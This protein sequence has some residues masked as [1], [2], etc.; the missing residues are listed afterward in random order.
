M[1][2]AARTI[3]LAL[4]DGASDDVRGGHLDHERRFSPASA[5]RSWRQSGIPGVLLV[6]G[7]H[8]D[9]AARSPT[10]GCA[11]VRLDQWSKRRRVDVDHSGR[12]ELS[13]GGLLPTDLDRLHLCGNRYTN[14]WLYGHLLFAGQVARFRSL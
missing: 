7:L 12:N 5:R 2:A 3:E 10:A 13:A 6:R 11:D 9:H 1:V 4:L 14:R 8:P